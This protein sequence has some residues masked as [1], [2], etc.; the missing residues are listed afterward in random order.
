MSTIVPGQIQRIIPRHF[1][2]IDLAVAGHDN[3][4]IAEM[5][6]TSI[7]Q[8]NLVLRSPVAQSEI[9]RRR[10][11]SQESTTLA[12]DADATRGKALSI[13]Q[14][15]SCAAATTLENALVDE[16][17]EIRLKAANSILDRALGSGKEDRRATVV[18][19]TADQILLLNQAL[20]ESEH[21]HAQRPAN[22]AS[23]HS[24]EVR[25]DDVYQAS[26]SEH[27]PAD[28]AASAGTPV[29]PADVY[30]DHQEPSSHG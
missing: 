21:V 11:E 12:L 10:R 29:E 3:K 30:E 8:V 28:E 14:Q 17:P 26:G 16:K 2:I 15:A 1:K 7:G 23:A 4:V 5:T 20:K 6:E 19:I 9:A 24:P 25:P 18:N 27:W 13:L 22:N